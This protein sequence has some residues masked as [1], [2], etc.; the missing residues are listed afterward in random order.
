MVQP[1]P[2]PSL[3][4]KPLQGREC[5]DWYGCRLLKRTIGR[6][7]RQFIFNSAHIL[8]EPSPCE[9]CHPKHLVACLKLLYASAHG[10]H[11]PCD[12]TTENLLFW[13]APL[14]NTDQ[15]RPT[16]QQEKV[17]WIYRCRAK[18]YQDLIVLGGR[19]FYL[20]ELQHIR[21][22]VFCAYNRFHKALITRAPVERDHARPIASSANTTPRYSSS[23][24][25]AALFALLFAHRRTK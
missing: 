22:S 18:L 8:G 19:F 20:R 12:I 11:S 24:V 6:L 9:S 7:Q 5:R 25:L 16:S 4:S 15:Q 2:D 14:D 23:P 21:R 3:I 13:P 1:R 10:F 17:Q